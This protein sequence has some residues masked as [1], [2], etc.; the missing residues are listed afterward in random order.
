VTYQKTNL[1]KFFLTAW[2]LD[3]CDA[4]QLCV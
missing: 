4:T 3:I 2:H 1:V